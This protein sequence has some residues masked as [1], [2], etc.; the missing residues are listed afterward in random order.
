MFRIAGLVNQL[1]NSMEL[2]FNNREILAFVHIKKTAGTSL[3]HV[4]RL[5]F[6]L[7]HCDVDRICNN[8]QD[9]FRTEDMRKL[10]VINPL[11]MSIA[12]HS[13]LPHSRFI[14]EYP[15]TRYFTL[16]RNP[17]KRYISQYQHNVEKLNSNLTFEEFLETESSFNK[18]TKSIAGT[19]N[20]DLAKQTLLK[21]FFLVGI[22]EE[23]NGFLLLLKRKLEPRKFRPS[24]TARNVANRNSF[25]RR[26]IKNHHHKYQDR[27]IE[28]NFLDIEL[29]NYVRKELLPKQISEYGSSFDYDLAKFKQ[30]SK[31][32]PFKTLQYIDF[33]YRRWYCYP[34]LRLIR[35]YK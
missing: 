21:R 25:I 18:Q 34:A 14:E 33:F 3:T 29:Y 1:F 23:F 28:R 35:A 15:N 24:F 22:V 17:V 26:N 12:G 31:G 9:F 16:L 5:N 4:L 8:R 19:E 20:I 27:I 7:R 11:V 2:N 10:F 30:T 32:I 6:F 13:I